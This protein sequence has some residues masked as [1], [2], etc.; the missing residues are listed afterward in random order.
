VWAQRNGHIGTVQW[1]RPQG[2]TGGILVGNIPNRYRE[3][4]GERGAKLA[5]GG[6][7]S[8]RFSL[9]GLEDDGVGGERQ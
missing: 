2:W 9:D 3:C 5:C 1:N 6:I 4:F 7:A 8:V